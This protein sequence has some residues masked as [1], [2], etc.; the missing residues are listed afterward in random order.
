MLKNCKKVALRK[1]EPEKGKWAS[2]C[3]ARRVCQKRLKP[4]VADSGAG[5]RETPN[6]HSI[7]TFK[8]RGTD[9]RNDGRTD[10]HVE[11]RGRI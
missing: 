3:W 2:P 5:S 4:E 1:P 8:K 7:S 9:G 11:M 10:P 6:F